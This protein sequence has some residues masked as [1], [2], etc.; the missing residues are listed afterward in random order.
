MN[1]AD[2]YCKLMPYL[3]PFI[4]Q[5]IIQVILQIILVGMSGLAM[6]HKFVLAMVLAIR[7]IYTFFAIKITDNYR[8]FLISAGRFIEWPLLSMF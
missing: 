1:I 5:P 3:H 4:T 2:V 6:I 8:V 7:T